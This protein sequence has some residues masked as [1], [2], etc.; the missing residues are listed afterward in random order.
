MGAIDQPNPMTFSEFLQVGREQW[1]AFRFWPV[2]WFIRA[3]G[4]LGINARMRS[5][6]VLNAMRRLPLPDEARILDAGCGHAYAAFWLARTFPRYRLDAVDMDAGLIEKA[7]RI[8]AHLGLTNVH[9]AQGDICQV[10]EQQ[11]YD[12]IFSMDVLEH[13]PDDIGA[14]N[15]LRRALRPGGWLVLHLPKRFEDTRRVLPGY[16]SFD[17]ED[18]VREEYTLPE[19]RDKLAQTGFDVL[20]L[21]HGYGWKGELAFELNYL[22]WQV[23]VV[24]MALAVLT[25]P[26]AVRLAYQDISQDFEDGNSFIVI[27]RASQD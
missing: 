14:L 6:R 24:R 10:H 22:L 23:P 25:H 13:V 19:I 26:L 4:P 17:M 16:V 15:A 11:A 2:R 9:F 12:L 7:R 21:K 18:H 3:F 20:Y 5:G 1:T 8:Q 27:A